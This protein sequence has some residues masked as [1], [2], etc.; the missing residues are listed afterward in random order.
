MIGKIVCHGTGMIKR[1]TIIND[2][3][4]NIKINK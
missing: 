3:I 4:K 1:Q 2:F